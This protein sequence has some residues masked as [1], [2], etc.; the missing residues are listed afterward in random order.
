MR[1]CY[2]IWAAIR[3]WYAIYGLP[4]ACLGICPAAETGLQAAPRQARDVCV[5]ALLCTCRSLCGDALQS[6]TRA[7][8]APCACSRLR[9]FCLRP[10]LHLTADPEG[11]D[12]S[13]ADRRS[14]AAAVAA[15]GGDNRLRRTIARALTGGGGAWGEDA[16]RGTGRAGVE[17]AAGKRWGSPSQSNMS[18]RHRLTD[19]CMR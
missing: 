17:Q 15:T 7:G 19:D 4:A 13:T 9:V 6:R 18:V 1:T 5:H 11:A 16:E 3:R 14:A 2:G 12:S 8:H 10:Q